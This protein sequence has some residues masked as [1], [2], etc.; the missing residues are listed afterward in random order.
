MIRTRVAYLKVHRIN[1]CSNA[2]DAK[3]KTMV[4]TL[5]CPELYVGG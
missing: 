3:D 4:D 5:T 2:A 1:H